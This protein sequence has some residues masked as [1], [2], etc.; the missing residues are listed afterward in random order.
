M[1]VGVIRTVLSC[2]VL[3][4][5]GCETPSPLR[6]AAPQHTD[7]GWDTAALGDVGI[8][9]APLGVL[10]R[11][12][13]D[14]DYPNVHG[15]VLVRDGKLV[16]EAYFPGKDRS[17]VLRVFDRDSLHEQ[18]SVTK[19][20]T[21]LLVGIA[22]DQR[23]I[24]GPEARLSTFFPEQAASFSD[25][26]K[27]RLTLGDCLTMRAGL[28]WDE[29]AKPYSDPTNVLIA[30]YRSGDP[31]H[32]VLARPVAAT[33]GTVFDY[34]GGLSITL[35]EVVHR[36]SGL[37]TDAFAER[38][39]FGPL[40]ITAWSWDRFADST[41][42]ASGGLRLR[43]RDMAKIGQIMLNGG[44]WHGATIVSES[45]VREST[46][47]RVEDLPPTFRLWMRPGMRIA[48]HFGWV[49]RAPDGY[50]YQ[51]WHRSFRV[52]DR[53][54]PAFSAEGRGGQFIVVVPDVHLVAVFTGWNDDIRAGTP[55][56]MLDR[57]ILPAV[58]VR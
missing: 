38:V 35:G 2:L 14:G 33:P 24:A 53:V 23:R 52:G 8:D 28:A 29:W 45:W 32:Y 16:L 42:D 56:R 55:I 36:T 7:D 25:A 11:E 48:R 50:G 34:N 10:L 49:A 12:L 9:S 37:R 3:A 44:R 21:G 43:P 1:K 51:W 41:V 39:L 13:A 54:L 15:I 17:G 26:V 4:G 19:S 6:P 58:R 40:G 57:R 18:H 5:P 27:Q 46:R 22:I 20:I 47:R 30:M 31:V